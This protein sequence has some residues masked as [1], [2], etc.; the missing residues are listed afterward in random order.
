MMKVC[1]SEGGDIMQIKIDVTELGKEERNEFAKMLFKCGY[2]IRMVKE[3]PT[4][5]KI[6]YFIV[7]EKG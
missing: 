5:N 4:A 1:L 7:C 6:K 2:A 3:K